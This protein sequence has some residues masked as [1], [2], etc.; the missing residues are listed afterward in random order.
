[1]TE[2]A[3][4]ERE[5]EKAHNTGGQKSVNNGAMNQ[6][7]VLMLKDYLK[8]KRAG[9]RWSYTKWFVFFIGFFLLIYSLFFRS[10]QG[11]GISNEIVEHTALIS[12]TGTIE[13]EGD[14]SALSVSNTLDMA[15]KNVNSVGVILRINSPGGSPVQ[16]SLIHNE[17]QR[18]KKEFPEKKIVAV[19]EDVAAS[20][21]YFIAAAA[22]QIFVNK[23]SLVGSIG[24]VYNG[25]GFVDL[26]KQI[27][28]ER[29][30]MVSGEK[31]ALLDP[32]S[33]SGEIAKNMMQEIMD[34]LHK[35]F[36]DAVKS[37]RG[38]NL[39]DDPDIFSGRVFTG[40]ES[41]ELGLS[42][43][44]GSVRSVAADFFGQPLIVHYADEENLFEKLKGNL[45]NAGIE[46]FK[47]Y[48]KDSMGLTQIQ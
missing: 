15:F 24:V 19:V 40:E 42:D 10:N 37:G 18:L 48:V 7:F 22:D 38:S 21:G 35:H 26:L 45:V 25:F 39:L 20:G 28:V 33:P 3:N 5:I 43:D 9:R 29:R 2:L 36:I 30:L 12:L 11:I 8:E 17:I 41:L 6:V 27:G 46:T 47:S 4:N 1:M 32:F 44:Y 34:D 23:S 31:K 14:I 16:S 13:N